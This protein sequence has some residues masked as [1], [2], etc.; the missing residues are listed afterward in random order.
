MAE[1]KEQRRRTRLRPTH[2]WTS[3]VRFLTILVVFCTTYILIMPAV[4]VGDGDTEETGIHIEESTAEP[5]STAETETVSLNTDSPENTADTV[6]NSEGSDYTVSSADPAPSEG[7]ESE[8]PSES[9]VTADN[10]IPAENTAETQQ[11]T[12][13]E[14]QPQALL[15]LTFDGE[16]YHVTLTYDETAGIP[17]NAYLSVTEITADNEQYAELLSSARKALNIAED[18]PLPQQMARFFDITI[19]DPDNNE[20]TVQS[21]V[22]VSIAYDT[23]VAVGEPED[24]NVVHF[25]HEQEEPTVMDVNPESTEEGTVDTVSFETDSFSIYGVIYTVDFRYGEYQYSMEGGTSILLSQL[26]TSLGITQSAA[27]VTTIEVSNDTLIS[28]QQAENDWSL[29]SL[30]PFTTQETLTVYFNDGGYLIIDVSDAQKYP[31]HLRMNDTE[32]AVL[33]SGYFG[34]AG[35]GTSF[36]G[37]SKSSNAETQTATLNN[38]VGW[39]LKD[40]TKYRFVT[41]IMNNQD[42]VDELTTAYPTFSGET[43]FDAYF[44][45]VDAKL[46]RYQSAGHGSVTAGKSFESY[47]AGTGVVTRYYGYS[48]DITGATAVP[49]EGYVFD[50]WGYGE[51]STY[52]RKTFKPSLATSDMVVTAYF[53]EE[54]DVTITYSALQPG[55]VTGYGLLTDSG[56]VNKIVETVKEGESAVGATAV[57]NNTNRFFAAWIDKNTNQIVSTNAEFKPSGNQIYANAE[58]VALFTVNTGD[59]QFVAYLN[60]PSYGNLSSTGN[61]T[62]M[63]KIIAYHF[64]DSN[65]PSLHYG[66]VAKATSAD[67]QFAYWLLN[68]EKI[69]TSVKK[70]GGLDKTT[71]SGNTVVNANKDK[72]NLLE[73]VFKP[74]NS[75]LIQY[76]AGDGGTVSNS[77]DLLSADNSPAGATAEPNS[78]HT[79]A[80]WYNDGKLFSTKLTLEAVDLARLT[81][82]TTLTAKFNTGRPDLKSFRV[83]IYPS[84][85]AYGNLK[86]TYFSD[87]KVESGLGTS[88]PLTEKTY[89]K[90]AYTA[91]GNNTRLHY[92]FTPKP[93]DGYRFAFWLD[94]NGNYYSALSNTTVVPADQTVFTG[95]FAE[96]NNYLALF[97][98]D[99]MSTSTLVSSDDQKSSYTAYAYSTETDKTI[100]A[101]P[102]AGYVFAGWWDQ[103]G[104]LLQMTPVFDASSI[105]RDMVLTARF[106][107][108]TAG[109]QGMYIYA[110]DGGTVK[111][112]N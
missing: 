24:A 86:S 5:E 44:A 99:G 77:A 7:T 17:E 22:T 108:E 46:I 52:D 29:T 69:S 85:G 65:P 60:D 62:G 88:Y 106:A 61:D 49:D 80:G 59:Y 39:K 19:L 78:K 89:E 34:T 63:D 33:T 27:D 47:E 4:T 16:D 100:T 25:D 11:E 20:I 15:P 68:G 70:E 109:N 50:H 98:T 8:E 73:A 23:P 21:G 42:A 48:S 76:V 104:N 12:I 57:G 94:N 37:Q 82:D 13:P 35:S 75:I 55:S 38:K 40:K 32:A 74:T 66:I 53:R 95:Y 43:T 97:K 64:K 56:I 14:E 107:A 103:N 101:I 6:Q 72:L 1:R 30:Q 51:S 3:L 91:D 83:E 90:G 92:G 71:L 84:D 87:A 112:Q 54:Q 110:E 102:A 93:A 26:F 9:Q 96:V 31:I 111:A 28:V 18:E 81:E 41:W 10:N 58:Y 105:T 2:V 45:P 67:Y 79:F 36:D